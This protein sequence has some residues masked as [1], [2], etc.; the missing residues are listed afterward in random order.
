MGLSKNKGMFPKWCCNCNKLGE[1]KLIDYPCN[2]Y[3][4]SGT[5]R[6]GAQNDVWK[7]ERKCSINNKGSA[8]SIESARAIEL[9]QRSI[10]NY[11][12]IY[13]NY[14]GDFDSSSFTKVV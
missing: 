1:C 4:K 7:T 11:K 6:K 13:D 8:G 2:E 14:T 5:K 12:P 10:N 9:F 3:A